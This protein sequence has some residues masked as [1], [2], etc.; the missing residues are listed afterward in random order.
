VIN[1]TLARKYFGNDDPIGHTIKFNIFDVLPGGPKDTCFEI[2]GVVGG[3]KNVGLQDPLMP[4]AFIPYAITGFRD[5]A[6]LVRTSTAP[7]SM[8]N[9]ISQE[10]W[11]VDHS[12]ALTQTDH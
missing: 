1:E 8:I 12:I 6:I 7:L 11:A 4:Q 10:I 2:I 5:R 9:G 3:F